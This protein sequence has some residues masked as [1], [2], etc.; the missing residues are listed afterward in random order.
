MKC[1]EYRESIQNLLDAREERDWPHE[2]SAHAATCQQCRAFRD[3]LLALHHAMQRLPRV[4]PSAELMSSL[5]KSKQPDA[6]LAEIGWGPEIRLGA[7]LLL[8]LLLPY[9]AQ[10]FSLDSIRHMVEALILLLGV[11]V[12]VMSILKPLILGVPEHRVS[13]E[14]PQ[15]GV[16]A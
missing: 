13:L 11:T 16:H 9:I 12:F 8:P 15:I 5:R 10:V 1:E 2:M 14:K 3:S 7:Q 6:P 4:T